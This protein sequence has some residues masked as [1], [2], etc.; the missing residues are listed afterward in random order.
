VVVGAR[1]QLNNHQRDTLAHVFRHPL[2]HNIEWH[3]VLS[4][5]RA[6]GTVHETNKGHVVVVMAGQ[7]ETFEPNRHK[8]LDTEQLVL[9]R[10]LLRRSGFG[11]DETGG[12]PGSDDEVPSE[13]TASSD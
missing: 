11:P 2:S 8:D 12:S 3:S 4:L 9:L 7:T 13:E 6:L 10:R 1:E 5:C